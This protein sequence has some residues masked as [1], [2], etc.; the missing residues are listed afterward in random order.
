MQLFDLK[1]IN[2]QCATISVVRK[3]RFVF[4]LAAI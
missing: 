2:A 1:Y 3:E 4:D